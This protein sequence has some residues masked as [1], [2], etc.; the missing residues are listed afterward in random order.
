MTNSWEDRLTIA[1]L[2]TGWMHRDLAEWDK[3]LELFHPDGTI[4]VT[5]F[6]GLFTEFVK[7]S[8]RMG[9]SALV[10]KHL[11]GSP[12]IQFNGDK[13]IVETNAMIVI[14]NA[15]MK[16]GASVHNRFYDWVEKRN[17]VWK[18]TRRQS[19]YDF[20]SFNFP[21]GIVEI[22]KATAE[23]FPIAYAPLAYLLEKSGFPLSREFASKGSS[24]ET[25]MKVEGQA[26]LKG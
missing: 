16:L 18:I 4:E 5:W 19:I 12:M 17:G 11:I 21:Q 22:D 14:E 8:Q 13:A 1:D 6:E 3:M 7:G 23:K 24:L 10:T 15:Q 9:N 2:M 25:E 26:W 20:G